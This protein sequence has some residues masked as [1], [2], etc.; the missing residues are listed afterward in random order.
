MY[1][2]F[3]MFFSNVPCNF[4]PER[5]I[6]SFDKPEFAVLT[7]KKLFVEGEDFQTFLQAIHERRF[8]CYGL[9]LQI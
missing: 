8:D 6:K 7:G 4:F 9:K 5:V 1:V 2:E 3:S